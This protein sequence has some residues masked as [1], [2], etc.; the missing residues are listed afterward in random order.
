M[1]KHQRTENVNKF[2]ILPENKTVYNSDLST[3]DKEK[4][5]SWLLLEDSYRN[6]DPYITKIFPVFHKESKI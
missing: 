1:W 2:C 5:W 3:M 6:L 4:K